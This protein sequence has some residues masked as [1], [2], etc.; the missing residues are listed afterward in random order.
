VQLSRALHLASRGAGP[1]DCRCG[2]SERAHEHY[3]RGTDCGLCQCAKFKAAASV[4][5]SRGSRGE[6]ARAA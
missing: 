3:R 2:H 5:G 1:K 4:R 6:Q